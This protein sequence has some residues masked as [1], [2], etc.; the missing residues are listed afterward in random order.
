[1]IYEIAK[2]SFIP[3]DAGELNAVDLYTNILR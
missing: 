3:V 2:K 1:M